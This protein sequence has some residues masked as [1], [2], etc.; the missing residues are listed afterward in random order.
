[1]IE[2]LVRTFFWLWVTTS[3]ADEWR[4]FCNCLILVFLWKLR[5]FSLPRYSN[6]IKM[7]ISR[8][9]GAKKCCLKPS[10]S[11]GRGWFVWKVKFRIPPTGFVFAN[12]QSWKICWAVSSALPGQRTR[13]R[14]SN[15][16]FLLLNMFLVHNLSFNSSPNEHSALALARGFPEPFEGRVDSIMSNENFGCLWGR[17]RG[18]SPDECH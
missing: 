7:K 9:K 5:R 16:K 12:V 1:M 15:F 6:T 3:F 2:E 14:F 17:K 11:R 10:I 8:K 13:L 4:L 18:G